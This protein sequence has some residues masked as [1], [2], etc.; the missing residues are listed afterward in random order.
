MCIRFKAERKSKPGRRNDDSAHYYPRIA[1]Q[2]KI[3]LDEVSADLEFETS[4]NKLTV[5]HVVKALEFYLSRKLAQGYR[6]ELDGLGTFWTSIQGLP[7]ESEEAV[8]AGHIKKVNI[9][10]H[11]GKRL[12]EAI[13]SAVF[14]KVK[15]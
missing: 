10:F 4:L 1:G 5:Y 14:E 2:P 11:P 6:I 15:E 12:H 8:S 3:T 9:Q 13:K 7:A